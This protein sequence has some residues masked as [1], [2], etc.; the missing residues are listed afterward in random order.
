MKRVKVYTPKIV[1]I[2]LEANRLYANRFRA[3]LDGIPYTVR[4]V[5]DTGYP[6]KYFDAVLAEDILEFLEEPELLVAEMARITNPGGLFRIT[7]MLSCEHPSDLDNLIWLFDPSD[8]MVM[9]S[10]HATGNKAVRVDA[11]GNHLVATGWR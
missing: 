4:D 1:S 5:F 2:S 8:L 9:F 3:I 10:N 7:T 6:S 11:V